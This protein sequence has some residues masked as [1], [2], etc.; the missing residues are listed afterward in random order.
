M[1][2]IIN[3]EEIL[4]ENPYAT[5]K[6]KGFIS[7]QELGLPEF[8]YGGRAYRIVEL[9]DKPYMLIV[10]NLFKTI[11]IL[12]QKEEIKIKAAKEI[13]VESTEE[14]KCGCGKLF[15]TAGKLR[16]HKIKCKGNKTN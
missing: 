12:K 5:A 1:Y 3:N 7:L 15:E 14:F 4:K 16:G 2:E 11:G 10:D 9:K 6:V 13:K 8:F